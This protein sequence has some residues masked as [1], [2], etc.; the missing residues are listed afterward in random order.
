MYCIDDEFENY[1]I[2]GNTRTVEYQRAEVVLAPC[3]Y[4][5]EE[6]GYSEDSIHPECIADLN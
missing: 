1:V 6:L 3:N 5:H 4:L 2:Y